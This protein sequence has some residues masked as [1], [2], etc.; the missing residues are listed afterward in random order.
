[1]RA[2]SKMCIYSQLDPELMKEE[3][4]EVESHKDDESN[5]DS[6]SKRKI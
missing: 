2:T 3:T 5:E 4:D 1:L 6:Q